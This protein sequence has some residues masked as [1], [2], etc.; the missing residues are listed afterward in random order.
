MKVLI[1]SNEYT[2]P[3]RI[4]NPIIGRIMNSLSQH[5]E[6]GSVSFC[7]FRN[8]LSS[9][10]EI[11]RAARQADIVHIQFGG[12]Y[13]F[14][15]WCCL[16]GVRKPKLLT[17]H[18]TDIHAGELKTTTKQ[19]SRIRIRLNQKAS[20][21]S[22]IAFDRLGF[23]TDAMLPFVPSWLRKHYAGK[24]FIQPLGVDY[25]VFQPESVETACQT[26]G[27][28]ADRYILF[29][30]KS[31]T[32]L[33]RR[34]LAE[35]IVRELGNDYKL[36]IMCGVSPDIVP[37]Y[38]NASQFV[39]LTSDEEGSP[40]IS[41]EA[42]ALDKRVFSVEVG[43]MRQQLQGLSDSAIISREPAQAAETIRQHLSQPY[44]DNTRE[45][46]RTVLD[47]NCLADG[48]VNIYRQ[49]LS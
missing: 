1:V 4:G 12:L 25:S 21:A 30:D 20:F 11:R 40:N 36:L 9:F 22:I 34:D 3:G 33:K 13:A 37:H 29:S 16:I 26:L 44:T 17:F 28:P 35:A 2:K 24:L 7:P 8:K 18:G 46:R 23:V 10:G 5:A 42:M 39:L 19:L 43:D 38:L 49:L 27:I 31:N 14:L 41:R 15:I 45:A 6:V 48:L 32:T 47:F